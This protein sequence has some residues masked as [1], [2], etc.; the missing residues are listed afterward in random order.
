MGRGDPPGFLE[1]H[2]PEITY[3]DAS[4]ERRLDASPP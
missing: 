3:F 2:S 4:S 1:I